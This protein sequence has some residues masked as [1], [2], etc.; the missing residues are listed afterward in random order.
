MRLETDVEIV[1]KKLWHRGQDAKARGLFDLCLVIERS[2]DDLRQA[3][4]YLT[5]HRAA[6][7]DSIQL[8]R[9]ILKAQFESI[10]VRD[11]RPS[12]DRSVDLASSFLMALT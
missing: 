3:A 1:A 8:R 6:F 2:P 4:K 9:D 11:S 10:D 7:L 12:F 5:R